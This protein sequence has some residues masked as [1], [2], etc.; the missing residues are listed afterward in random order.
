M[1]M[2]NTSHKCLDCK[3]GLKKSEQIEHMDKFP[4]HLVY[5]VK[6]TEA[7]E[8][9]EEGVLQ[10]WID[11]ENDHSAKL[12]KAILDLKVLLPQEGASK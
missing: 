10:Q 3:V 5:K 1:E 2:L 9:A 6:L 11:E 8:Q 4:N 12:R 7:G